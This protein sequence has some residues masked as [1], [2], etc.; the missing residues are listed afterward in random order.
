MKFNR[1][2]H[3]K[4]NRRVEL[5]ERRKARRRK[6]G[7]KE[8]EQEGKLEEKNVGESAGD[9]VNLASVSAGT[10]ESYL[11]LPAGKFGKRDYPELY[12]GMR[13]LSYGDERVQRAV[14]QLY[15][16]REFSDNNQGFLGNINHSEALAINNAIGGF[17]PSVLLGREFLRLLKS[18]SEGKKD[19][20]NGARQ[21][22]DRDVI[23]IV[24]DDITEVRV[25][26]RG[27]WFADRYSKKGRG[28]RVTTFVF[29]SGDLKE[30]T[31]SI[32]GY[33]VK[34]R[35][36]GISMEDWLLDATDHGLPEINCPDG[37]LW[38]WQPISGY[39]AG[40]DAGSCRSV[41][42][43]NWNPTVRVSSLG[44]REARAEVYTIFDEKIREM[45]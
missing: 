42:S 21:K 5:E 37:D 1:K 16:D 12:I 15:P 40:F 7:K 26:W 13:R 11:V 24:Y 41:L 38:Y 25:P 8:N 19:V 36:P 33:L 27:E 30:T 43:C 18:G 29:D 22:V 23:K 6:E 45:L 31:E 4:T 9:L 10:P 28:M 2:L 17:T 39:V 44:V 35:T 14:E 20:F 3:E 32:R 34:S